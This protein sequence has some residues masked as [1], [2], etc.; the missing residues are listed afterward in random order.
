[1]KYGA[2]QR[3]YQPSL[4]PTSVDGNKLVS[5]FSHMK[6]LRQACTALVGAPCMF[7]GIRRIRIPDNYRS[8]GGSDLKTGG[9]EVIIHTIG[10]TSQMRET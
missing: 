3:W 10:R 2:R 6:R 5:Q 9:D 1:M 4:P 7:K 8:R